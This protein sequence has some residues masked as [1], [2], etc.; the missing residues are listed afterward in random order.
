M[1]PVADRLASEGGR[2]GTVGWQLGASLHRPAPQIAAPCRRRSC[3]CC[4]RLHALACRPDVTAGRRAG[5]RA[6]PLLKPIA[7]SSAMIT[8]HS[9]FCAHCI[10]GSAEASLPIRLEPP[11]R[12]TP[13]RRCVQAASA[14]SCA[15]SE[16]ACSACAA[17]PPS[18][19]AAGREAHH[20]HPRCHGHCDLTAAAKCSA[21]L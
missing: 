13:D 3:R 20:L 7:I 4:V 17:C 19:A 10:Q 9:A 14:A 21:S 2:A 16:S 18:P 15:A 5:R 1:Q 12:A 6:K 8:S 11:L